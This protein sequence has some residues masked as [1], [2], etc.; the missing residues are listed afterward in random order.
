MTDLPMS[1]SAEA[2]ELERAVLNNPELVG[3]IA[4][5]GGVAVDVLVGMEAEDPTIS[6]LFGDVPA[7]PDDSAELSLR[8]GRQF[9]VDLWRG[10]ACWVAAVH[11]DPG[12][13]AQAE[14]RRDVL[15]SLKA[16]LEAVEKL[17]LL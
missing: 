2:A 7:S 4:V 17:G 6:E 15:R 11:D 12:L 3:A 16:N 5:R 14:T 1:P 10:S 8:S 13:L 9:A